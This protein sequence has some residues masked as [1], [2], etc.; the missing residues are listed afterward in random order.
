MPFKARGS[1][2]MPHRVHN[3]D[4]YILLSFRRHWG[5]TRRTHR[6]TDKHFF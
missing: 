3:N 5:L 2:I 6:R 1:G 4:L